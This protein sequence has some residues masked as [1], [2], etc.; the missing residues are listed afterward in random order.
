MVFHH[1]SIV[2]VCFAESLLCSLHHHI[3]PAKPVSDF[4][5]DFIHLSISFLF[6]VLLTFFVRLFPSLLEDNAVLD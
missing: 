4:N 3:F 5:F 2:D 6:V 1:N